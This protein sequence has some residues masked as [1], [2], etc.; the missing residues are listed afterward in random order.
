MVSAIGTP[1]PGLNMVV[2]DRD[3]GENSRYSLAIKS[4]DR[5]ALQWF[6][7]EPA[8]A[9][10]RTP[11]VVRLKDNTGLDFDSG[12]RQVQFAVAAYVH[13]KQVNLVQSR[14]AILIHRRSL[15]AHQN[16]LHLLFGFQFAGG[17]VRSLFQRSD[18]RHTRC[19]R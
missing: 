8:E 16:Y 4:N 2:S 5:R 13:T 15:S 12:L 18:C 19:K 1:L 7:V 10:G 14:M 3:L 6:D 9:Y 11:V 17:K